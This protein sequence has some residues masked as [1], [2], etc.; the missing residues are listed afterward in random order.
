[1][2]YEERI[3][4]DKY[5]TPVIKAAE[6]SVFNILRMLEEGKIIS[7][8]INIHPELT[9]ADISACIEY[10]AELVIISDFKKSTKKIN[11]RFERRAL[12]YK[13]Y[14]LADKIESEIKNKE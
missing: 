1:M 7:E 9:T 11:E 10:A 5:G 13:L 12:A 3:T 4:T 6:I 14:A 2:K 8:I